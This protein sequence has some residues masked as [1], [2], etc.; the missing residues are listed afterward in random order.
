MA[1]SPLA[2]KYESLSL[3]E[4]A[5]VALAVL[6]IGIY[7]WDGVFM[8]PLRQSRLALASELATAS[9]SG[10]VAASADLDDPRQLNLRRAA[11]LQRHLQSL[12]A[13][14]MSST[15]GFV[16]SEKMVEVLNDVLARQGRLELVSIRNLEVKSLPRMVAENAARQRGTTNSAD[17]SAAA[18]PEP[19][20]GPG[21]APFVHPIE[22]IIEGQYADIV[23][24]LQAL[25][26]LPY[27]FH[28]RS[29]ELRAA[30]YPRNRVRIVLATFSLDS[31]WLGV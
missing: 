29:L 13:Q 10:V 27:K 9:V 23:G 22:I 17:D 5:L 19:E 24:Y 11:E 7:L 12:D 28:W 2:A 1:A 25:E 20:P 26:K 15:S 3:R 6:G 16:S 4:R 31:T 8:E 14:L 21:P 18:Q 30:G